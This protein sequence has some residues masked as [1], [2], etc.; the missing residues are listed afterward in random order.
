[1][2]LCPVADNDF[3]LGTGMNNPF[4]EEAKNIPVLVECSD[5]PIFVL[6]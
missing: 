6:P 2:Y 3:Y 5:E 4:M 1:M